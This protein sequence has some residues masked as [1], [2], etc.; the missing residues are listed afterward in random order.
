MWKDILEAITKSF[1]ND[2]PEM[3]ELIWEAE[4]SFKKWSQYFNPN[5]LGTQLESDKILVSIISEELQDLRMRADYYGYLHKKEINNGRAE[6][7]IYL[8]QLLGAYFWIYARIKYKLFSV[9]CLGIRDGWKLVELDP[10][11]GAQNILKIIGLQ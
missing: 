8:H 3:V 10:R 2:D 6:L 1:A 7:W 11:Q 4:E 5:D 9:G